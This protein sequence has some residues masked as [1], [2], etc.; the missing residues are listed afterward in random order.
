MCWPELTPHALFHPLFSIHELSSFTKSFPCCNP[1]KRE[2]S[3]SFN[4]SI[5]GIMMNNTYLLTTDL[6]TYWLPVILARI[7]FSICIVDV[8]TYHSNTV[9][10]DLDKIFLQRNLLDFKC[11]AFKTELSGNVHSSELHIHGN[12]LHSTNSSVKQMYKYF[13]KSS[14][15]NLN[16]WLLFRIWCIYH[17]GAIDL[18]SFKWE[19]K[20]SFRYFD[21]RYFSWRKILFI[22]SLTL[23]FSHEIILRDY[24]SVVHYKNNCFN[25]HVPFLNSLN[26]IIELRK[27]SACSP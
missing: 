6:L 11:D 14:S 21:T 27:R 12:Q 22:H 3:I 13:S 25:I 5:L 2:N 26:E 18:D 1:L 20:W 24:I 17:E 23:F 7:L 19:S 15:V 4:Y 9:I 8:E 10:V 16:S